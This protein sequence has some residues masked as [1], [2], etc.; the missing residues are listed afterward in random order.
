MEFKCLI[1]VKSKSGICVRLHDSY[2]LKIE[3]FFSLHPDMKNSTPSCNHFGRHGEWKK[4]LATKIPAKVAN[5]RH[6][7][8]KRNL[9]KKLSK[10]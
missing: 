9:P 2:S 6:T 7:D 1:T 8:L 4:Y 5:W 3:L 10:I